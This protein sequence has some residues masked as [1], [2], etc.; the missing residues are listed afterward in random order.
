MLYFYMLYIHRMNVIKSFNIPNLI[1]PYSLAFFLTCSS[2]ICFSN[3]ITLI[4]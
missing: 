2:V 3:A 1:S 4:Y